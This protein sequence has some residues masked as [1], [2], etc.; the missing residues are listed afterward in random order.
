M[1]YRA[2]DE[3]SER[4]MV[5]NNISGS[6]LPK[7]LLVGDQNNPNCHTPA[8]FYDSFRFIKAWA[9]DTT[10][11]GVHVYFEHNND[12]LLMR[13]NGGPPT[14]HLFVSFFK[15]KKLKSKTT[16]HFL[17]L[18]HSSEL[19]NA[20]EFSLRMWTGVSLSVVAVSSS[21]TYKRIRVAPNQFVKI[22]WTRQIGSAV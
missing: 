17:L 1:G 13:D 6:W 14:C 3:W 10:A 20:Y 18:N 22:S 2:I 5:R 19:R 12:G 15:H 7:N 4:I 16:S 9:S 8:L 21:F 11:S